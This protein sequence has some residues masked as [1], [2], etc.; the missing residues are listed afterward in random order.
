[1]TRNDFP[2]KGVHKEGYGFG[3]VRRLATSELTPFDT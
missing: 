1:M 2:K 3:G